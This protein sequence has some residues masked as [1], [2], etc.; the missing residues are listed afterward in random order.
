MFS[1]TASM[2]L[3]SS[4]VCMQCNQMVCR[5]MSN[6]IQKIK[7]FLS[8]KYPIGFWP[9]NQFYRLCDDERER[10]RLVRVRVEHDSRD[11]ERHYSARSQGSDHRRPG[12][13]VRKVPHRLR[14]T[15]DRRGKNER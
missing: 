5:E 15:A 11:S 14:R 3:L 6:L 10:G 12:R 2:L 9:N 7:I 13:E 4:Q 1:L 8:V